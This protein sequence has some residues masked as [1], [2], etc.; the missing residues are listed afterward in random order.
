M[1]DRVGDHGTSK[2]D[3]PETDVG[4]ES[5]GVSLARKPRPKREY[6]PTE[7]L[8]VLHLSDLHFGAEHGFGGAGRTPGDRKHESLIGRLHEDLSK[9]ADGE[10]ALWPDLVVVTGDLTQQGLPDEFQQAMDFL[11]ELVEVVDLPRHRLAVV[12]GNHDINWDA[13]QGYFQDERSRGRNTRGAIRPQM[14]QL[15]EGL[16]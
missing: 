2:S 13:C 5:L 6:A 10:H 14:A 8:T 3:A 11:E 7:E 16:R 12:P 9:L 1:T 4:T 15:R